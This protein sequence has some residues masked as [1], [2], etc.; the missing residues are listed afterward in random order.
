MRKKDVELVLMKSFDYW[1][2]V[3][4]DEIDLGELQE[5]SNHI[6]DSIKEDQELDE[7]IERIY[8][9]T[10][11]DLS[12]LVTKREL[13]FKDIY[14]NSIV[15]K[16]VDKDETPCLLESG[17]ILLWDDKSL[18]PQKKITEFQNDPIQDE[19]NYLAELEKEMEALY[20]KN[21]E[22]KNDGKT[23]EII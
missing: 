18:E 8:A 5:L 6:W 9:M 4:C 17:A 2:S 12:R 20:Q 16:F 22:K 14:G 21:N 7:E 11:R 3:I 15:L 19:A 10:Q 23:G 13:K 1:K